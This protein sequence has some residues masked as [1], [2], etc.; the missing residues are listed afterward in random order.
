MRVQLHNCCCYAVLPCRRRGAVARTLE[1]VYGP[2]AT[3]AT[4]VAH[5]RERIA[6]APKTTGQQPLLYSPVLR[7]AP[8]PPILQLLGANRARE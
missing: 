1:R 6:Y 7:R 5:R 8:S 4:P 2:R 3:T